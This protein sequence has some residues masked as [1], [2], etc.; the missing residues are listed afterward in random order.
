VLTCT[1][2]TDAYEPKKRKVVGSAGWED[3]SHLLMVRG[4]HEHIDRWIL[5]RYIDLD[6]FSSL[7]QYDTHVEPLPQNMTTPSPV[8]N[9]FKDLHQ[10]FLAVWRPKPELDGMVQG[11]IRSL[12]LERPRSQRPPVIGC[13]SAGVRLSRG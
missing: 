6:D 7:S 11:V 4:A 3:Q 1:P 5:E 8:F 10:Q 13:V 9:A 12:K 2:A